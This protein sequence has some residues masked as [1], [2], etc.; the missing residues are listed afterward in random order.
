MLTFGSLIIYL[1]KLSNIVSTSTP[2][3]ARS[4]YFVLFRSALV[5]RHQAVA[6]MEWWL[7]VQG[8]YWRRPEGPKTDVF[9][10]GRARHPVTHVSCN[11]SQ[12]RA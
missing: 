5:L 7:P 10:D 6:G 2:P 4:S 9:R 1:I 8:A 3:P 11:K 12:V